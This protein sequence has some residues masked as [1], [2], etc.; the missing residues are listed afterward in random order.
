MSK[1]FLTVSTTLSAAVAAS[2][3]FTVGY[4]TGTDEDSF[5]GYGHKAVA[6][7]NVMSSPGDF[8]LTFGSASIT[9]TYGSSKT[10]M[11][12]GTKVSIDLNLPGN[13]V[14]EMTKLVPDS[15][16]V[17]ILSLVRVDLGSPITKDPN[18]IYLSA[19]ITAGT[20]IEGTTLLADAA[21]VAVAGTAEL[22]SGFA[23]GGAPFGRNIKAAWTTTSVMTI[24]GTDW[25]GNAMVESSASGTTFTGKKAFATVT[26]ISVTVTVSACTVGH[27]D[28]LGL[29]FYLP[30]VDDCSTTQEYMDGILAANV[31]TFVAGVDTKVTA[32]TGDVRGTYLPLTDVP[33]G[34]K[35]FVLF[36]PSADPTYH[37]QAQ[38]AG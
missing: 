20:D 34:A 9:F 6:I 7:G 32:L 27:D 17:S 11:P 21:H 29:P 26:K 4:P 12:A 3:T 35:N 33:N 23:A 38:F 10:T 8:T 25:Q 28:T 31:G 5:A 18:G 24:T 19:G 14:R 2:G 22:G 1:K 15:P 36:I 30:G 37:G 16:G 13:L